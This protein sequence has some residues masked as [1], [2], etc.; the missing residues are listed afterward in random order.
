MDAS[1]STEVVVLIGT[2][3]IGQAGHMLPALAW[4]QDALLAQTPSNAS[5]L[6]D[7]RLG[8]GVYDL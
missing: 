2:G 5:A 4:D 6:P 7:T 3:A 8:A 1:Q